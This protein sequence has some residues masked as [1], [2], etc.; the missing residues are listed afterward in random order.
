MRTRTPAGRPAV[1]P[2]VSAASSQ[3]HPYGPSV[4]AEWPKPAPARSAAVPLTLVTLV[5]VAPPRVRSTVGGADQV[6]VNSQVVGAASPRRTSSA[7]PGMTSRPAGSVWPPGSRHVTV[8]TGVVVRRARTRALGGWVPC[9]AAL[10]RSGRALASP[11]AVIASA[12]QVPGDVSCSTTSA[13]GVSAA[14]PNSRNAVPSTPTGSPRNTF[15]TPRLMSPSSG[16][17]GGRKSVAR[18]SASPR[19][20]GG[21]GAGLMFVDSS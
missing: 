11:I 14:P 3:R 6:P 20:A 9:R 5:Q 18:R 10:I 16:A 4:A 17:P 2:A 21:L 19:H 15:C 7:S 13:S 12:C 1:A 8:P